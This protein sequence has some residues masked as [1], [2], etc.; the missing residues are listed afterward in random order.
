RSLIARVRP[1]GTLAADRVQ[2]LAGA[3]GRVSA[4]VAYLQADLTELV[5]SGAADSEAGTHDLDPALRSVCDR[6]MALDDLT[7][8]NTKDI[9]ALGDVG[10]GTVVDA[11]VQLLHTLDAQVG[12]TPGTRGNVTTG[13]T[14]PERQR[15]AAGA[16]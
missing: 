16:R 13:S 4:Q 14:A 6:L 11:A 1:H 10:A 3:L 7:Q 2:E 8:M 15:R 5:S 9:S 12:E